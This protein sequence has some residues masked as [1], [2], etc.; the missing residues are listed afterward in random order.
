MVE[1]VAAASARS[2]GRTAAK[3]RRVDAVVLT[4]EDVLFDHTGQLA[5]LAV[6]RAEQQLV[7]EGAFATAEAAR[8]ALF[9]FRTAFGYRKRF[10]RFVDGLSAR[11]ALSGEAAA[12][13]IAAY[14]ESQLQEARTIHPFARARATLEALATAGYQLALVLVGKRDVQLERLHTLGLHDLFRADL[15]TFVDCN[16][17]VSQLTRAMKDVAR[18]LMLP[19]SAVL[20]VGRKVFYEIKAANSVGMITA[21]MVRML[22]WIVRTG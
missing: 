12:R 21:R 7:R 11:G 15:I 3:H 19:P 13:V 4:L 5:H 16:P 8:E 22:Q 9:T 1:G 2:G 10:P 17:S 20:F 18:R 14:Y 6:A